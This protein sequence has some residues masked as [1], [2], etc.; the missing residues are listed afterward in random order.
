MEND[1]WR[2][3]NVVGGGCSSGGS[4]GGGGG[5]TGRSGLCSRGKFKESLLLYS[6]IL[7]PLGIASCREYVFFRL[8]VP[9]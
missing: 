3:L 7:Y 2:I 4:G 9:P 6:E 1:K 8:I 5:V